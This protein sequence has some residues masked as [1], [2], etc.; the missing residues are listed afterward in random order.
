M[1][2][3]MVLIGVALW[4][5]VNVCMVSTFILLGQRRKGDDQ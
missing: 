4:L 1:T 2:T 5:A 3:I